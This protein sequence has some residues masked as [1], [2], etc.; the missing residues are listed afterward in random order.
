MAFSKLHN[1]GTLLGLFAVGPIV[2][3]PFL[4]VLVCDGRGPPSLRVNLAEIWV[5]GLPRAHRFPD[6]RLSR[7][8]VGHTVPIKC[9]GLGA[10]M[11]DV[12]FL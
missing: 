11:N 7:I 9:G 4:V 3:I 12:F 5:D 10:H 8:K 2:P 1:L 6:K